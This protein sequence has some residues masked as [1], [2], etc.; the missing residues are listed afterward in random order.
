[1][2]ADLG[3]IT[4]YLLTGLAA[5]L[6]GGLLGLGGGFVVVPCL[7]AI[8]LY[9]DLAAGHLMQMAVATSLGTIL[10]TGSAAAWGHHQRGA[11]CWCTVALLSPG[12]LLGGLLGAQLADWL[13]SMVLRACYGVFALFAAAQMLHPGWLQPTPAATTR[14]P[15]GLPL[16]GIGIGAFSAL[17]GIGGGTLTVPFLLWRGEEMRRAL[18]ISAACGVLA[19]GAGAGGMI[20]VGGKHSD[21]PSFAL[22]YLYLPAIFCIALGAVPGALLGVRLAYCLSTRTL[23]RLFAVFLM[24]VGAIMLLA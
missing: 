8:F 22:G 4:L 6:S 13:S 23:K 19:A 9:Q 15:T 11:V 1:M 3:V 24:V 5:G 2:P 7:Y 20:W 14:R 18:G 10:F 21:L 12:V 16:A 17:L